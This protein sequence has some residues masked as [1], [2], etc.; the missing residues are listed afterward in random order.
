MRRM[1]HQKRTASK[2]GDIGRHLAA[3][4]VLVC[5]IGTLFAPAASAAPAGQLMLPVQ[6]V[7]ESDGLS[8][9]PSQAFTY[10]LTPQTPNAPLP[11]GSEAEGYSFTISGTREIE[12]DPI[13]FPASGIYVY[14]IKCITDSLPGY[15]VDRQVYTIEVHVTHDLTAILLVYDGADMKVPDL[16]FAHIYG[17]LPSD[18]NAMTDP[19][20]TKTIT[21][22][23]PATSTFTFRL[24]AEQPSNPMPAGSVNGI[25]TITII[26]A[27]Q[28]AF[29][30]WSYPKEG[31]FRY[32]VSEV[33]SGIAGYS[34]DTSVYTI[35]D[36]VTAADGQLVV[37]RTITNDAGQQVSSLS[38]VN[39][40]THSGTPSPPNG[41]SPNPPSPPGNAP[42]I[43]PG[44]PGDGPRTGDFSNPALWITL[45]AVSSALL[46]L[47]CIVARKVNQ[48]GKQAPGQR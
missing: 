39:T 36:V 3:C 47:I 21:G 20:V 43:G 14:E 31:T 25:K 11:S 40:Y 32:T 27:G 29:G 26:G 30:T 22:T 1:L 23:P 15:T 8:V 12:V 28:A 4:L 13:F 17:T 35:T 24:T 19:P 46:T 10:L 45:I 18:P 33:N 37:S 34:Y 7:F 2:A 6:Q 48:R 38:F 5:L 42:P 44:K 16:S 41:V 9:P